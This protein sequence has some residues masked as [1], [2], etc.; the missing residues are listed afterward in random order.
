MLCPMG[1]RL[2]LHIEVGIHP[3]SKGDRFNKSFR[4]AKTIPPGFFNQIVVRLF[5]GRPVE[6]ESLKT[7]M[8]SHYLLEQIQIL[9]RDRITHKEYLP[10]SSGFILFNLSFKESGA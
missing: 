9:Y 7:L 6:A 8:A 4:F 1:D 2:L 5:Q 3:A 10:K